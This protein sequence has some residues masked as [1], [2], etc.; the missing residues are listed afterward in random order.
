M[1]EVHH[2]IAGPEL[3][4]EF[5]ACD[6]LF[7]A[8]DQDQQHPEWLLRQTNGLAAAAQ[9]SSLE[10]ELELGKANPAWQGLGHGIVAGVY[11]R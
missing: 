5:L 10:I 7:S 4:L 3:L 9:F 1:L 6:Q 11:Y 8:L 2:G